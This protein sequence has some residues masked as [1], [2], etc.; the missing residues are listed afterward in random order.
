MPRQIPLPAADSGDN[1]SVKRLFARLLPLLAAIS[2][3]GC[4]RSSSV[5]EVWW[6][7]EQPRQPERLVLLDPGAPAGEAWWADNVLAQLPSSTYTS[8]Q[9]REFAEGLLA[10]VNLVRARYSLPP[11]E[12]LDTLNRAAQAHALDEAVRD[13][14]SHLTPEGL[15]S[16]QRVRAAGGG[17]VAAGGEN[18][19]V[20]HFGHCTPAG[21]VYSWEHHSGHRELLLNP[22]V[23]Y[24]GAGAF[25]YSSGEFAYFVA[26]L[27]SFE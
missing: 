7:P 6:P 19:S 11:V 9:Q 23:R 1:A 16:R 14:W 4:G 10:E 17:T 22:D 20:G 3:A 27:V 5:D 8:L 25:G 12:P 24:M 18:S 13:Y 21:I 15:T 2:M 26:L